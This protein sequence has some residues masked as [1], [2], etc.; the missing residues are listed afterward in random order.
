MYA[1]G[2]RGFYNRSEILADESPIQARILRVFRS[3]HPGGG[4]FV[5]LDGSV[6]F[7][8]ET[9]EYPLLR[10]LVTRDGGEIDQGFN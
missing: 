3:D 1:I 9:I 10:A 7:V 6:R 5:F 4:Q 8:Q 2:K